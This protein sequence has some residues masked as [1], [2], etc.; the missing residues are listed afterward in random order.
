MPEQIVKTQIRR[1]R[2]QRLIGVYTVC[3]HLAILRHKKRVVKRGCSYLRTCMVRYEGVRIFWVNTV[4]K[5]RVVCENDNII[6]PTAT[7]KFIYITLKLD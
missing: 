7:L 5:M 6:T 1:C 3:T 4:A 2:M